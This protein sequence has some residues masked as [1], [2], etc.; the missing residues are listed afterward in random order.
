MTSP[1]ELG[2]CVRDLDRQLEFYVGVLGCTLVDRR[3][4]PFP[5]VR[6]VRLSDEGPVE[7]AFLQTPYGERIKLL[8][9]QAPARHE[10]PD[11]F[12]LTRTGVA[13]L[14][15]YVDDIEGVAAR[16]VAAGAPSMLDDVVTEGSTN[17]VS[18]FRDPEGNAVELVYVEDIST[19]RSD[20]S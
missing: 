20:L 16:L 1:L 13:Y 5:A 4:L 8:Q 12:L 9:P 10:D 17:R 11:E 7:I 14:T 2:L 15:F 19:Y 6:R 3:M 18:F